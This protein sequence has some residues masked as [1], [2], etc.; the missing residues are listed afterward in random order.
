VTAKQK[1]PSDKKADRVTA[2]VGAEIKKWRLARGL[3][4]EQ[5]GALVGRTKGHISG[6]ENGTGNLSLPIFLD[7][8]QKLEV[9]ASRLL[10]ERLTKSHRDLDEAVTAL[11]EAVGLSE[12]RWLGGLS[13]SDA[14]EAMARA[15]ERITVIEAERQRRTR[16][17][18]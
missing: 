3:T 8:C 14:R 16:N 4:Q 12:I 11:L 15:H 9:P 5:L 18:G 10:G 17:T 6:I 7:V 2:H 13:K 1:T